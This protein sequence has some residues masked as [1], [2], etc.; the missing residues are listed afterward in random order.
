MMEVADTI[1]DNTTKAVDV[2]NTSGQ[3]SPLFQDMVSLRDGCTEAVRDLASSNISKMSD[4]AFA[5]WLR[6]Y[7]TLL[8]HL[9]SLED[10]GQDLRTVAT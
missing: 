8:R 6:R 5:S 3:V 4:E 9:E 10:S 7:I 2:M 1:A